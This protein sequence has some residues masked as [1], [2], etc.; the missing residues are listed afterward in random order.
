MSASSPTPADDRFTRVAAFAEDA[1][2]VAIAIAAIGL[3]TAIAVLALV[4]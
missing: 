2:F 1:A 4:L 3:A